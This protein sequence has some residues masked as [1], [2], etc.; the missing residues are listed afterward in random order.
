MTND[1][2]LVHFLSVLRLVMETFNTFSHTEVVIVTQF[3]TPHLDHT[4]NHN[5]ILIEGSYLSLNT[6][7][8]QYLQHILSFICRLKITD[9]F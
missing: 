1:V 8:F 7:T 4:L 6:N 2:I 9:N 5:N 3:V